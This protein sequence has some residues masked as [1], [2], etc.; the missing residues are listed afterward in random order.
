MYKTRTIKQVFGLK[1]VYESVNN[2][3]TNQFGLK[4]RLETINNKSS[5]TTATKC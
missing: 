1:S 4:I 5:F 3:L 2:I